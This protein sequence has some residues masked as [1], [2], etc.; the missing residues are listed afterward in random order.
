MR[1]NVSAEVFIQQEWSDCAANK[2]N[3]SR[4]RQLSLL[5]D[6]ELLH[7]LSQPNVNG[8]FWLAQLSEDAVFFKKTDV[9]NLTYSM[10]QRLIQKDAKC[11]LTGLAKTGIVAETQD[12]TGFLCLA[13]AIA[14]AIDYTYHT[15][16]IEAICA[17]LTLLIH[18]KDSPNHALVISKCLAQAR[19]GHYQNGMNGFFFLTSALKWAA[20]KKM[21][22]KTLSIISHILTELTTTD[23]ANV[24]NG[25]L[26]VNTRGKQRHG[27]YQLLSA[28]RRTVY[29]A[30]QPNASKQ[31]IQG[32]QLCINA[33][34]HILQCLINNNAVAVVQGLARVLH[35]K[36]G[37]SFLTFSIKEALKNDH[38]K[39]TVLPL[40]NILASLTAADSLSVIKGL[41]VPSSFDRYKNVN[42]FF[43][44]SIALYLAAD[45]E[46]YEECTRL[47]Y[48][49]EAF[50]K[51]NPIRVILDLSCKIKAAH[52]KN[53]NGFFWLAFALHQTAEKNPQS[54]QLGILCR[55]LHQLSEAKINE[56]IECE[57]ADTK[58]VIEGLSSVVTTGYHQGKDGFYW[59]THMLT[60]SQGEDL[61][62]LAN[63]ILPILISWNTLPDK[64]PQKFKAALI[65]IRDQLCAPLEKEPNQFRTLSAPHTLL[66]EILTSPNK[67]QRESIL[68]KAIPTS[69][70]SMGQNSQEIELDNISSTDTSNRPQF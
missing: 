11:A 10:L 58:N 22:E 34:I 38:I 29:Y 59:L 13:A 36:T 69:P 17:P 20:K 37:L 49:V 62:S 8:F 27:L 43:W 15:K 65:T 33:I 48:I 57:T 14:H 28:L 46:K 32:C 63:L 64:I 66:A 56:V 26:Q 53:M 9:Y 61:Q 4:C 2:E 68:P 12:T 55:L 47:G 6:E 42:S 25:L 3:V 1:K 44:L 50:I 60:T 70:N 67:N 30:A 19:T 51:K 18:M 39:N 40:I 41:S 23:A 5:S 54:A 31:L 16:T 52:F 7:I 21:E 24:L 45:K 35:E